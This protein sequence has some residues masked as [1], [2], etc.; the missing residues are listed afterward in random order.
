[1]AQD[2]ASSLV[3]DLRDLDIP[4]ARSWIDR[5]IQWISL[6][7]GPSWVSY[8]AAL[9]AFALMNNAVFWV[10]GSLAAG[11]FDRVRVLD[12]GFIV[13]FVAL[14]HHLSLVAGRSFQDFRPGLSAADSETRILEYRLTTLPRRLGWLALLVGI[15]V[16]ILSVQSDPAAY[17]L[18]TAMTL[19]PVIYQ[20]AALIFV[21]SAMVALIL[22]TIRQLR[23]VIDL[24]RQASAIDLFHLTP[25]LVTRLLERLI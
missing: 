16:G 2:T 22:Q 11:S 12:S 24:H 5:L 23:L 7:P 6:I 17:G 1:M 10:D 13:F 4:Y 20:H 3:T 15:G 14:Y 19:L 21:I 18:D 9:I 8:I 25:V